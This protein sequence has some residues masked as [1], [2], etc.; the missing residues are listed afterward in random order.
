MQHYWWN[1]QQDHKISILAWHINITYYK[2]FL[3]VIIISIRLKTVLQKLKVS[4]FYSFYPSDYNGNVDWSFL[5]FQTKFNSILDKFASLKTISN[6]AWARNLGQRSE[7]AKKSVFFKK[8]ALFLKRGPTN[9]TTL[10]SISV[11]SVFP[12]N[13]VLH[14]FCKRGQ[15]L[16]VKC[17]IVL[18]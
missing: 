14:N 2:H 9:F 12:Q 17:K 6:R 13:K 5:S 10:Y 7:F 16:I 4:K 1:H 18:H 3:L 11:V 8:R 15:H